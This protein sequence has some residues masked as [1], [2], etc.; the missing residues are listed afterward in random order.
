MNFLPEKIVSIKSQCLNLD[1]LD[2]KG[3]IAETSL[4]ASDDETGSRCIK[5]TVIYGTVFELEQL[6]WVYTSDKDLH[7]HLLLCRHSKLAAFICTSLYSL[8]SRTSQLITSCIEFLI[9]IVLAAMSRMLRAN[10]CKQA[11][12]MMVKMRVG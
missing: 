10:I 6:E 3:F 9:D 2:M 11:R 1:T 12:L 7:H 8:Q 4:S 5:Q